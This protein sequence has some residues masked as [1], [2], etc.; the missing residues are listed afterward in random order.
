[1]EKTWK[2]Y[3]SIAQTCTHKFR[4]PMDV[5]HYLFTAEDILSGNFTPCKIDHYGKIL[6]MEDFESIERIFQKRDTLMVCF[7]DSN[8]YTQEKVDRI[9]SNIGEILQRTFP[10]KSCFEK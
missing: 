1:M 5:M 4:T 3:E 8:S 2:K 10:M 9:N 6:N 7:N